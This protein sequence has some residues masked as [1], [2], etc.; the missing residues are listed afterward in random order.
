MERVFI[1]CSSSL[2]GK[3]YISVRIRKGF[4]H[5]SAVIGE[6]LKWLI[7][8]QNDPLCFLNDY[9]ALDVFVSRIPNQA[10]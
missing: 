10:K 4:D 1:S 9:K 3:K 8:F 5:K 2:L 7:L 6:L